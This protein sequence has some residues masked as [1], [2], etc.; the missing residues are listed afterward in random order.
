MKRRLFLKASAASALAAPA[1]GAAGADNGKIE[2]DRFFFDE[3]FAE[4]CVIALRAP[5]A[6]PITGDVTQVWTQSLNRL[7]QTR[8]LSLEGVTTESFYFCLKTLLQ[9]H[10]RLDARSERISADLYAWSI[11]STLTQKTG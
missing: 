10:A 2:P 1:L 7:S 11:R 8:S 9:S 6:T 4:A 5:A 3:R